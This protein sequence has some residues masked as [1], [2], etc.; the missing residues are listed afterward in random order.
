MVPPLPLGTVLR[1]RY[2]IQRILGQGG[3]GRTYLAIDQ[4]RFDERCVLK[5]FS[6]PY[7]DEALVEKSKALFQ[8]EASTLYQ[9]QHPQVPRFWAAFEDE[10]RLFLAQD[11]IEGPT[12]RRLLSDRKQRG[13]TFSE[14]E[15][16]HFLKQFLPVLVY[17]HDRGIIHRDVSPE[18][19]IQKSDSSLEESPESEPISPGIS[20][21]LPV[22]IDF[23]AVKEATTHWPLTTA[24]TRVGKVGYAP[25]EQ[26]QTGQVYPNS[27]LY[28]LA[29]TCL[30][31]LTGKEPKALL[32]S[33]TLTW[34]WERYTTISQSLASILMRMLAMYPGDR[35][36]SARDLLVDLQP[37]L[38]AATQPTQLDGE[39]VDLTQPSV[40]KSESTLPIARPPLKPSTTP[41]NHPISNYPFSSHPK[42]RQRWGWLK[43]QT[44]LGLGLRVGMSA[45][46]VVAV[47]ILSA[48][49]WQVRVGQT[50]SNGDVWVSGAKLPRSEA[51]RLMRPPGADSLNSTLQPSA[52]AITRSAPPQ[53]IQFAPGQLT[54]TLQGNLQD[55]ELQPY[56]LQASQGQILT[57]SLQGSNVVMN[58]LRSNQQG[59]DTAAY[60]TRSW[61]GD[62]PI[63]DQYQIQI[64]G[65]G[66][67][68][69]DVGVTPLSRPA[70][71]QTQ[72]VTFA[73][74]TN[75]TTVTGE[76]AATHLRR[77]LL[78]A[79]QGQ[80]MVLKVAAGKL[81][82]SVI[83]PNGQRIGGTTPAI[84][85]WKGRLPMDGDYAIELSTTTAT[86][87]AL[88]LAIF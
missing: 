32:D 33:Q 54:A 56:L 76:L 60:Q 65:T 25:P 27:D 50:D 6:V 3:F 16:K 71:E 67:Y 62:L 44:S 59:V 81:A 55:Y 21:S 18:N 31:L 9:L 38:E 77:Y 2:L 17:I 14:P 85:E 20:T 66:S 28:A 74:Q 13:E 53:L 11:F 86:N 45:A 69:L 48:D 22:L 79:N 52:P 1:Q 82:L 29:A 64:I 8:R 42:A 73:R 84:A 68:I 70:Q 7:Q 43:P 61:T 36:P 47:G 75:S 37:I 39:S 12:Y 41:S 23:G 58:I 15:I 26:L 19:L 78:K 57:A 40:P 49:F 72:R 83:A 5:E 87:F 10:Q 46:L 4:E 80:I 24:V 88:S 51:S 34:Q 30:V 63:D 35:Y